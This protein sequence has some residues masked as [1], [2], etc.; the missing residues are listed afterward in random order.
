LW[1]SKDNLKIELE[2]HELCIHAFSIKFFITL[3][4]K[5]KKEERKKEEEAFS[6]KFHKENK[7]AF[8]REFTS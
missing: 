3:K 6:L 7:T 5:K 2:K 4:K 8:K 1:K